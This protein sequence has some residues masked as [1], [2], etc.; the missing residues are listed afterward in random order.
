MA[1]RKN[2]SKVSKKVQADISIDKPSKRTTRKVK[3]KLKK[4]SAGTVF[5]VILLLVLGVVGGYFGVKYISRNDCF[6]IVGQDEITL[7]IG[8]EPY[9]DKGVKV[10]AFGVDETD[11]V[12]IETN[13]KK[14]SDGK[15]YAETEGTYYIKYT[16]DNIK[17]GSIFKVQKIR[18]IHFV[19]P[20][21]S[22]EVEVNNEEN[23]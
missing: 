18:L 11:K 7:E 1:I 22:E 23:N 16:V 21:E 10:V 17:Y 4:L 19:E 3:T 2:T 15:Y 9:E 20:T 5:F 13:L 8:S 12:Q 6:E 14:N